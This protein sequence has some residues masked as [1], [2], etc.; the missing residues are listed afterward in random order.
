MKRNWMNKLLLAVFLITMVSPV[1]V[2]AKAYSDQTGE[3]PVLEAAGG[4][5][6]PVAV[7]TPVP[8]MAVGDAVDSAPA[9]VQLAAPVA[10]NS[11][12]AA[13]AQVGVGWVDE[14]DPAI[15]WTGSWT[16]Q[17]SGNALGGSYK[18]STTLNNTAS[19]EF[20]GTQ[21]SLIFAKAPG[22]GSVAIRIDGNLV[23]TLSMSST[24]EQWQVRWDSPIQADAGPHTILLTHSVT[25]QVVIDAFE[26][27]NPDPDCSSGTGSIMKIRIVTSNTAE[28]GQPGAEAALPVAGITIPRRSATPFL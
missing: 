18:A 25:G 6:A 3:M 17:N 27:T 8:V 10:I 28:T 1:P 16:T 20:T 11:G 15:T 26:V 13:P 7:G 23:T 19:L 2:Q 22:R 24:T 14:T 21:I 4:E 9:P 12:V 5:L